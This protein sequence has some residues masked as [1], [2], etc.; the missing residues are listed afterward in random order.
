MKRMI[1]ALAVAFTASGAVVPLARAIEYR[2]EGS[3][4]AYSWKEHTTPRPPKESGPMFLVGGY[5]AGTPVGAPPADA[6]NG[7]IFALGTL[8]GEFDLFLGYVSYRTSLLL[9][10]QNEVNTHT[11]YVGS[12]YEVSG[13]LRI[14]D[15]R[16]SIEPFVGLGYRWWLRDV[17]SNGQVTGYPERYWTI[18][19]RYG[20]R[21]M[22]HVG[23]HAMLHATASLDP[24][25]SAREEVDFSGISGET[26][27]LRNGKRTGWTL[28]AGVGGETVEVAMFWRAT[29]F[30]ASNIVPCSLGGCYQPQ[31][32]QNLI[33]VKV[34]L[35]F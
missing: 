26:L 34:G 14:G 4:A 9:P 29:R 20:L 27:R 12:R 32:D 25:L 7:R 13:G 15:G 17:R 21:W 2:L 22:A 24:L 23:E 31:S 3:L 16:T 1:V 19:G 30:G 28:E 11:A 6:E 33:G 18:Y 35:R 5:V 8:R 10:P